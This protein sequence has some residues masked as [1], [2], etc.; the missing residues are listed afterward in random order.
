MFSEN[1]VSLEMLEFLS[2][3]EAHD[4]IDGI[5]GL[6]H[7][8][9]SNFTF[10]ECIQNIPENHNQNNFRTTLKMASFGEL[11]H[12]INIENEDDLVLLISP[13]QYEFDGYNSLQSHITYLLEEELIDDSYLDD[14]NFEDEIKHIY[15]WNTE[16]IPC[17]ESE[18]QLSKILFLIFPA[19]Q[20]YS[21]YLLGYSDAN[22]PTG[23]YMHDN[24]GVEES[25]LK[26]IKN[27]QE[28][29]VPKLKL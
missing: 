14:E 20:Q 29:I 19:L 21:D 24:K 17:L 25:F 7:S 23:L 12:L 28:I 5:L 18:N 11:I 26:F 27:S 13:I 1:D 3:I 4:V 15:K 9:Q 10:S 22:V 6:F 2:G 8:I 16:I